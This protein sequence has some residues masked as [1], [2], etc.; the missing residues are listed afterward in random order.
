MESPVPLKK[1]KDPDA[2]LNKRIMELIW[3]EGGDGAFPSPDQGIDLSKTDLR[4][5]AVN[6]ALA[7]KALA[8]AP[9]DKKAEAELLLSEA[10]KKP[11]KDDGK[12]GDKL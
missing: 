3:E 5:R 10:V 4:S 2:A 7:E 12:A 9:D 6:V 11:K 8:E 1:D